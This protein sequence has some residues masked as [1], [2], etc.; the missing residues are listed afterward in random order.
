MRTRAL[1][2]IV[3][4]VLCAGCGPTGGGGADGSTDD[5]GSTTT[6]RPSSVGTDPP[7][8]DATDAGS[9]P[10]A[11]ITEK[12]LERVLPAVDDLPEGWIEAPVP[13]DDRAATVYTPS[14]GCTAMAKWLGRDV[15]DEKTY[16]QRS[17][18]GPN[19]YA[20][21]IK[22]SNAPHELKELFTDIGNQ[23]TACKKIRATSDD[24]YGADAFMAPGPFLLGDDSFYIDMHVVADGQDFAPTGITLIGVLHGD[25]TFRIQLVDGLDQAGTRFTRDPKLAQEIA[26]QMDE[27][28]DLLLGD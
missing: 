11:A 16:V 1:L 9:D 22:I 28:L 17:F 25:V 8:T 19:G 7:S 15:Q 4:L 3:A 6:T 12:D 10:I 18:T 2:I 14:D 26:K 23:S 21:N 27:D 24:G 13:D 20:L 5:K